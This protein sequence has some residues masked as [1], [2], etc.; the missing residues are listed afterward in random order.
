MFEVTVTQ[1]RVVIAI[2]YSYCLFGF[3]WC[4]KGGERGRRVTLDNGGQRLQS[5]GNWS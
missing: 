2:N 5:Q 4:G 1:E 3:Q